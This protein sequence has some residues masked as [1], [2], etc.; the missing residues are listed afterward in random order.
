MARWLIDRAGVQI[1]VKTPRVTGKK[2]KAKELVAIALGSMQVERVKK[3]RGI[4]L[5]VKR[6]D[7]TWYLHDHETKLKRKLNQSG[8]VIYHLTDRI[9]Y[10]LANGAQG[11]H[12]LHAAA[13]SQ[14]GSALVIPANSG[15]GKSSFTAWL[16]ANGF[17]YLTDELILID[18]MRQIQGMARPIQI[19]PHGID[20]IQSLLVNPEQVQPGRLAN[21]VPISSLGGSRFVGSASTNLKHDLAL[22][23]FPRY[24][25]A[26]G[27]EFN[28]LSSAEAGMALMGNHVNARNLEGHG[29]REMMAIIRET[30]CYAL[31]YG[32]FDK[33]PIDFT[34]QL[35]GLLTLNSSKIS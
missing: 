10:H 5:S 4:K 33:L 8:D 27:Y 23:I 20:A 6:N 14:D 31:E 19:K 29:F 34:E 2:D 12:C 21:A 35:R 18:A 7:G 32:G 24:K 25:A 1:T 15:A 13:V 30:P 3:T 17:D 16:V 9:V 26:S 22:M 28:K 11:V